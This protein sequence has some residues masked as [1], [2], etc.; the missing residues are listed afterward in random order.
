MK[1]NKC[2]YEWDNREPEPKACPRCKRRFDYPKDQKTVKLRKRG[3]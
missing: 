2:N 3:E 1:C